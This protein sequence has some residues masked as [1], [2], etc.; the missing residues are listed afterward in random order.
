MYELE[1]VMDKRYL[2]VI[3]VLLCMSVIGYAVGGYYLAAAPLVGGLI[4]IIH[5][6]VK[7]HKNAR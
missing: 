4:G 7:N 5:A 3:I 6:E 2:R 1:A